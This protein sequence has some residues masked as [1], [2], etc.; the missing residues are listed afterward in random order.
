[1]AKNSTDESAQ[2]TINDGAET[3][4]EEA[5]RRF[6]DSELRSVDSFEAAL[7]LAAA[8]YGSVIEAADEIGSGFV[9]LD[10]KDRLIGERFVILH[11]SFPESG[12]FRNDLGEF[13]HFVAAM[14]VTERN[15]RYVLIDGGTGI[16][17]QLDEWFVRSGRP[18][19]LVVNGLRKSEYDL[20]DGSGKGTTYYLN[21]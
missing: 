2:T 9:M 7:A 17:A 5:G 21:V 19:G 13:V 10:N 16:Y 3:V 4:M 18:G 6:S 14:I 15:D 20:P 1:M 11:M 8:E 12:T